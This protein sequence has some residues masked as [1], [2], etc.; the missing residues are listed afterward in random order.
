MI[1]GE[2]GR[3]PQCDSPRLNKAGLTYTADGPK[4]RY[5]CRECHRWTVLPK[6]QLEFAGIDQLGGQNSQ[7]GR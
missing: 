6:Q 7:R 5:Y 3:C 1:N 2:H 4:Q